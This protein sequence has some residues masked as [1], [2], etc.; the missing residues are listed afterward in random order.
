[1]DRLQKLVQKQRNFT[2]IA[3]K[4]FDDPRLAGQMLGQ[5]RN[6]IDGMEPRQAVSLLRD[7]ADEHRKRSQFDL[8]ESTYSELVR[9]Y[10]TEPGSFDAM[11]WLIQFWCSSETAWQ[12]TRAMTSDSSIQQTKANQPAQFLQ[13]TVDDA[14]LGDDGVQQAVVS[15]DSGNVVSN[16]KT[17]SPMRLNAKLDFDEKRSTGKKPSKQG[18]LKIEQDVDWRT[19]A[20]ADWHTRAAEMAKQL[21]VLKPDIYRSAEIQFPLAAMRRNRGAPRAADAIMRTFMSSAIDSDT[22]QLAERELWASYE[23][24][25]TPQ[26][27]SVCR[28]TTTRPYLDGLLSDPCWEAANEILLVSSDSN[29]ASQ[30]P[31]SLVMFSYDDN[32]LYLALSFSRAEGT[33]REAP[34]MK[35]RKH[36]DDV[37]RNDRLTFRLDIDRDYA[38]W[39]EFQ[40]D[41]RGKTTDSCWED[42]RW[43]PQWSVAAESDQNTWRIEAA[44]PW[45]EL[46]ANPPQRGSF[47]AVS[48]L[49]TIPM[50]G[51]QS[52]T[53]PATNQ[54]RPSSFGLLK[55]E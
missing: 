25:E 14:I 3:S 50:V 4:S 31:K 21:E 11:R 47:Y 13:Q 46:V 15:N 48:L 36:D 49:R 33:P 8:V 37:S 20:V 51:I 55:L 9:R 28:R 44:I 6:V 1:M 2:A 19:G 39:Y 22:K 12:R 10:P 30:S 53:Q 29:D 18:R 27:Y 45:N 16:S 42:R 43:N 52:W 5:I 34:Q 35:G 41:Q 54:P 7:L 24:V 26:A 23:T 32:F 38:T 40:I 17:S